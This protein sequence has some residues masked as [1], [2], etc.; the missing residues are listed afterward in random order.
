MNR[1]GHAEGH[2]ARFTV[3]SSAWVSRG[4]LAVAALAI[5]AALLRGQRASPGLNM[6]LL[7]VAFLSL[8]VLVAAELRARHLT[9]TLVL[10]VSGGLLV[11]AAVVPPT[12]STDVWSYSM[13]GRM[14]AHYQ[15]S[16]YRHSAADYPGDPIAAR[17]A[18]FWK[19]TPSV[20]GPLFT[21]ISAGGMAAA[22]RS[23]LGAR[24]FFQVTAALA[25]GACLLLVDR[26][27][28]DPVALAFLGINPITMVSV[29]NGGH[30]DALVGLAVL[31]AALVAVARRPVWAGAVLAAAVL[32]KAAAVVPAAA[33]AFWV[34]RGQG[35]RPLAVLSATLAG[36]VVLGTVAGGGLAV[37]D[38]LGDAQTR[39]TAGSLWS[40]PRRWIIAA[41]VDADTTRAS[42]SALVGRSLAWT[43]IA[44]AI[45]LTLLLCA[46]RWD[47]PTPFLAVGAA[48]LA[49]MLVGT[50]ILPWY[51][52]WSLPAL[53]I[54]WRWP[55]AWLAVAQ[56]G[57]LQLATIPHPGSGAAP[58]LHLGTP[59]ERFQLDLYA[60]WIPLLEA[61]AV[62]AI[63]AL[64]A[65]RLVSRSPA[66]PPSA[67][68]GAGQ[69]TTEH[70]E[71]RAPSRRR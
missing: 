68:D 7:L 42:A 17:V 10:V 44:V 27:T 59:V 49:Y 36:I 60:A 47:S 4:A 13:Y 22:G 8:G 57:L 67:G 65:Y 37:V 45:G 43:S 1:T 33:I 20:Y 6:V 3:P 70:P 5:A 55:W 61:V 19:E 21:A 64:T 29:V 31:V 35:R 41:I 28:R 32:V 58:G 25:V 12:Q 69:T 62:V 56:A 38:A 26:R 63:V 71:L 16:P 23:T 2:R 34:W 9:R 46:R 53:A 54:C 51:V 14:V 30:N 52:A 66:S 24:L 39:F 48:V 15:D 50:H 11:L 40:G 18:A